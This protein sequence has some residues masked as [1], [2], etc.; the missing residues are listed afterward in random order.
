ML[1]EGESDLKDRRLLDLLIPG[2]ELAPARRSGRGRRW[3]GRLDEDDAVV[4]VVIPG[5]EGLVV[6]AL[7]P[8]AGIDAGTGEGQD[9]GG[10]AV[11]IVLRV[12]GPARPLDIKSEGVLVHACVHR[13]ALVNGIVIEQTDNQSARRGKVRHRKPTCRRATRE[14]LEERRDGVVDVVQAVGVVA[15]EPGHLQHH[16]QGR[17]PRDRRAPRLSILL[18]GRNVDRLAD[19]VQVP[20]QRG[21]ADQDLRNPRREGEGRRGDQQQR[22]RNQRGREALHGATSVWMGVIR[23]KKRNND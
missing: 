2:L 3:I 8:V 19:T 21:A 6:E 17:V 18:I 12:K 11:T 9:V 10:P 1:R 20:L 15:S 23:R 5:A 13:L 14:N 4:E 7:P 16:G 22:Q